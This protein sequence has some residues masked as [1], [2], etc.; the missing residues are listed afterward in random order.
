MA[1]LKVMVA[2]KTVPASLTEGQ[3][4]KYVRSIVQDEVTTGDA[5]AIHKFLLNCNKL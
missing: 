1:C 4:C 3:A 2:M 5:E